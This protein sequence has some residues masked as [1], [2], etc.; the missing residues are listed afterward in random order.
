VTSTTAIPQWYGD[1][2]DVNWVIDSLWCI[3]RRAS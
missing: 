1:A 3:D 2:I